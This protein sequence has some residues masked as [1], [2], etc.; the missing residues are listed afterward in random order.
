MAMRVLSL[1]EAQ[2]Q[3]I[4]TVW[5]YPSEAFED[6]PEFEEAL[7]RRP[8]LLAN[9][10]W[11]V[12]RQIQTDAGRGRLDLLGI[13]G[14]GQIVVF[15]IKAGKLSRGALSQ[16]IE[17]AAFI[18]SLPISDLATLISNRS[19]KRGIP[20]IDDFEAEYE[21]RFGKPAATGH[22]S[23]RLVL[24]TLDQDDAASRSVNW[25]WSQGIEV[26]QYLYRTSLSLD[27]NT[28]VLEKIVNPDPPALR[29]WYSPER[30]TQTQRI[31]WIIAE[32]AKTDCAYL[33]AEILQMITTAFP[34]GRWVP[35]VNPDSLGL[36]WVIRGRNGKPVESITVRIYN[37]DPDQI[38]LMLFD[39][40]LYYAP[41]KLRSVLQL[42]TYGE[43]TRR[44]KP[45]GEVRWIDAETWAEH[46]QALRDALAYAGAKHAK[47]TT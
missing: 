30:A 23:V 15:E 2:S 6:E 9:D 18:D 19:G 13:D 25:L 29:W 28:I 31:D 34:S 32:A 44:G 3:G 14:G 8:N 43:G 22:I 16:A 5:A 33:H 39:E 47:Q 11:L 36:N 45:H 20:P 17:Y 21:Q 35:R 46:G 38:F 1:D 37:Y 26:E 24:V 10:L 27:G 4:D 7:T 12:G 40:V 41:R 42:F